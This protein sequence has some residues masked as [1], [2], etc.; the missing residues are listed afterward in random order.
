MMRRILATM[1]LGMAVLAGGCAT[2]TSV[3]ESDKLDAAA[4]EKKQ[5]SAEASDEEKETQ[6][7]EADPM[8]VRSGETDEESK[9]VDSKEVFDK[10][11]E[12]YSARR[13]EEALKHYE[14]IIRYFEDSRFYRSSLYNGGLSYEKLERWEAAARMYRKI[15]DE[16]PEKSDATDAYYRLAEV[17]KKLGRHEEIAELMTQ[18]MLRE[19]VETFDRIEAHTR[20]SNALLELEQYSEAEQGFKNLLEINRKAPSEERLPKKSRYICQAYFGLGQIFRKRQSDIKLTLPPES[21]GQDLDNKGELLLEAQKYYLRALRQ[22][23]PHWSVASGYMIGQLYEDFYSDIYSAE[24]P[25]NLNDE[26]VAMYFEELR[27]KI[28]P[29]M[30]RAI[31]VYE[32]NLSLSKRIGETPENN[33]WVAETSES[34]ERMKAYMNNPMTRKQVQKLALEGKDFRTLWESYEVA[35]DEVQRAL[36]EATRETNTKDEE[37]DASAEG[38]D[39]AGDS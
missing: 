32:K 37:D 3:S 15:I 35:T 12:A 8:L 6:R 39:E 16:F 7:I 20:R 19:D 24:V 14:T 23:H 17:Y 28:Q 2:G 22:H 25:E 11:Y 29:L 36:V 13:Y 21:M 30:E 10:A 31:S 5:E 18:V 1:V 38:K 27:K 9:T 4:D 34:L 26:Q 33:R